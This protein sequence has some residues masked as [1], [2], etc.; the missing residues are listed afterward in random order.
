MLPL[1]YQKVLKPVLF[2]FD[3]ER[4]HDGF[5]SMGE[6][7]GRWRAGRAL[8][9]GM[10]G[11]R[12][13]DASVTVD[14]LR[15]RTPIVLAA[16]FD[17]NGRLL[18]VLPNIG[19]GG[20][21]VGSVTALP[22]PGNDPPRMRRLVRSRSIVVNKGLKNEGVDVV[23]ERLASE[24]TPDDFVVGVSIARSNRAEAVGEEAG[25]EDYARSL[26]QLVRAGVGDYYTVN[27]SCPNVH[28][29]ESF[30]DPAHLAPLLERLSRVEHD[31]PVYAKM[32][33]NPDWDEF[34]RIV[35]VVE[36]H[37]LQGLVI[38]NLNKDYATL[39]HPGEAPGE[40]RGGLSGAPCRERSTELVARTREA[41]GDRFTLM[42]CG[43]ILSADDAMDKFRAGADLVQLISGMIFTGPHLMS[44]IAGA[45]AREFG[46]R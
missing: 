14:G 30:A 38:G 36:A 28:G 25:I 12:G 18:Q 31:R 22:T 26:E 13:P 40:Y 29:G 5:V 11:Y 44:D 2:R 23:T 34:R 17:Y 42:A 21:E 32:P 43:G 10:Y 7:V 45:W 19:F 8:L 9:S 16:G 27:I 33:I 46:G 4:V 15:Y 35:D 20:V 37:G 39:D 41:W 3:P 24:A 1:L 6:G